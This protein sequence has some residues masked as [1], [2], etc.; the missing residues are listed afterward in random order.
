MHQ[1]AQEA[2]ASAP[3]SSSSSSSCCYC[4][5][6]TP[7]ASPTRPPVSLSLPVLVLVLVLVTLEPTSCS[8]L[9]APRI[10]SLTAPRPRLHRHVRRINRPAPPG[11]EMVEWQG[12]KE[13]GRAKVDGEGQTEGRRQGGRESRE[14]RSIQ[15]RTL[16]LMLDFTTARPGPFFAQPDEGTIVPSPPTAP[17][18]CYCWSYSFSSILPEEAQ[19]RLIACRVSVCAWEACLRLERNDAASVPLSA[20]RT[21]LSLVRGKKTRQSK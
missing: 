14:S 10:T 5:A 11:Q 18:P 1:S 7:Q 13:R 6:R 4:P 8:T 12:R 16:T 17:A 15:E 3:F 19:N 20:C 21:Y 9:S 2:A